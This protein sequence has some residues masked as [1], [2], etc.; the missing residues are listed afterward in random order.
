[1]PLR[2]QYDK[3]NLP[4]P[5]I[6]PDFPARLAFLEQS[7]RRRFQRLQ[8]AIERTRVDPINRGLN[9]A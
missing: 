6:N 4:N 3:A 1:M 9:L 8:T 5:S 2:W 7:I